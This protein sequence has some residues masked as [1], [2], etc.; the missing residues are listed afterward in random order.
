LATSLCRQNANDLNV[1]LRAFKIRGL[2]FSVDLDLH[3]RRHVMGELKK[4]I[5]IN[6]DPNTPCFVLKQILFVTYFFGQPAPKRD[7]LLLNRIVQ[8]GL[9]IGERLFRPRS[10]ELGRGSERE[11]QK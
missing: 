5:V 7:I 6:L 9:G 4:L 3:F 11:K 10:N 1:N 8:Y 2:N